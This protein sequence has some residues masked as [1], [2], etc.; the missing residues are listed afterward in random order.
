M[1]LCFLSIW[2]MNSSGAVYMVRAEQKDPDLMA[3]YIVSISAVLRQTLIL[4]KFQEMKAS[5]SLRDGYVIALI[6]FRLIGGR[7]YVGGDLIKD[8]FTTII[9]RAQVRH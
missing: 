6:I 3:E 5:Y 8:G 4:S 9:P 1:P 7:G 2:T